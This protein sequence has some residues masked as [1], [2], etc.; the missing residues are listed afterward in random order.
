MKNYVTHGDYANFGIQTTIK[1]ELYVNYVA[2]KFKLEK[3]FLNPE[4]VADIEI[5]GEERKTSATSAVSRAAVGA[6][7]L[8]PV[9]MAAALS[10]KKKGVHTIG[11]S[12]AD[13]KKSIIELD[14]TFFSFFKKIFINQLF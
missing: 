9:G 12:W 13:G 2:K 5:I 1:G 6:F 7:L 4:T 11:I 10:A 14:D 8:G 3:V